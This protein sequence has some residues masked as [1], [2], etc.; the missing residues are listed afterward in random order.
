MTTRICL[1][2]GPRNVSTALMYSFRQRPDT[3]VV[4]EPLYAHYLTRSGVEHPGADEVLAAQDHDGDA[5]VRDVILAP[6]PTP[7]LFVKNMAHH[8]PGLDRSFLDEVRSVLLVRHPRE[9]LPSLVQQVPEPTLEGTSLPTQVE[10]VDELVA[11]GETP[12]VVDSRRLLLD[13]A[14]VL[15]ALCERLGLEFDHGMLSWEAGPVPEDGVWAPY[16]YSGVHAS[17]GFARYSQ[18]SDPFPVSLEPLLAECEPLYE[19]IVAHAI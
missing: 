18:K 14:G 16:W 2:S 5:V 11:R 4:D 15:T 10:L 17:T 19:R 3:T 1:W 6:C 13:P 12:I 9:M 7:V 8:L